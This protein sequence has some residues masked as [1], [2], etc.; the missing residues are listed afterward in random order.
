MS[1]RTP[2][3]PGAFLPLRLV[4]EHLTAVEGLLVQARARSFDRRH[5]SVDALWNKLRRH[6]AGLRL[7]ADEAM[8]LAR[9]GLVARHATQRQAAEWV[10]ARLGGASEKEALARAQIAGLVSPAYR[11]RSAGV[12]A[13]CGEPFD[14]TMLASES[15]DVDPQLAF[16]ALIAG[17][18]LPSVLDQAVRWLREDAAPPALLRASVFVLG[19]ALTRGPADVGPSGALEL[20][21]GARWLRVPGLAP[22]VA[23]FGHTV[24]TLRLLD[25]LER[26]NAGSVE[27]ASWIVALGIVG[28]PRSLSPLERLAADANRP[29]ERRA[30]LHALHAI[31]GDARGL[32][33]DG[34]PTEGSAFEREGKAERSAELQ[35]SE[36]RHFLGGRLAEQLPAILPPLGASPPALVV[37]RAALGGVPSR[38]GDRS[39]AWPLALLADGAQRT[40]PWGLLP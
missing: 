23:L 6:E 34:E 9:L 1:G 28:L 8:R 25:A 32:G 27:R 26:D 14:E 35:S 37:L 18:E 4:E 5:V 38:L 21:L 33:E 3:A 39:S 13:L 7:R 10:L 19:L 36:E 22:V 30:A 20:L 29:L 15:R 40:G 16:W 24:T 12:A 31:T 11:R 2:V 17:S